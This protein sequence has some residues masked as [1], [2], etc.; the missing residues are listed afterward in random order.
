MALVSTLLRIL[1]GVQ[2]RISYILIE[3]SERLSGDVIEVDG[4]RLRIPRS[5]ISCEMRHRL[6]NGGIEGAD[7]RLVPKYFQPGDF[8]VQLG[9]GI[10]LTALRIA[11]F[12]GPTGR[13]EVVEAD[14]IVSELTRDNIAL[15]DLQQNVVVHSAAAVA[16]RKHS[17]VRFFRRKNF[18]SSGLDS[19]VSWRGKPLDVIEVDTIFPPVLVPA[20]W[21]GRKVLHCDVEGYETELLANPDLLAAFDVMIT[22]L[23]FSNTPADGPS[24]FATMFSLVLAA[25]F[26]IIDI[27]GHDMF[28]FGRTSRGVVSSPEPR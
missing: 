4:F 25:G 3:V 16:N 5:L 6:R 18:W 15:N 13:L 1:R 11:K 14:P 22:E 19:A 24:S 2:D 23:H 26:K 12:I 28:V 7:R 9:G 27:D 10:G 8:V 20:C 21:Q 17:R